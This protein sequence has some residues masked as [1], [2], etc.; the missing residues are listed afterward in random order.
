M[1]RFIDL[2]DQ[3]LRGQKEFAWFDTITDTFETF[4]GDQTWVSWM[5]FV[6]DFTGDRLWG[7]AGIKILNRYKQLFGWKNKLPKE[8]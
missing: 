7:I 3:I 8:K 6:N 2:G 4:S 1:I 5:N